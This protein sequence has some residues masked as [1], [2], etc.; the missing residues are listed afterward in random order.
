M[1]EGKNEYTN[2][3][4]GMLAVGISIYFIGKFFL[5]M[6]V[7]F[8]SWLG[9]LLAVVVTG[10]V[11]Y[12]FPFGVVSFLVGGLLSVLCA[13][14]TP[15]LLGFTKKYR[16]V[17]YR[18]LIVFLPIICGITY[19]GVGAPTRQLKVIEVIKVDKN[20]AVIKVE[21]KAEVGK[22]E[23]KEV[24]GFFDR[25]RGGVGLSTNKPYRSE[26]N[27]NDLSIDIN[28]STF[29][30]VE[31]AWILWLSILFGS[32]FVFL[33]VAAT[34]QEREDARILREIEAPLKK[35]IEVKTNTES[36]LNSQLW[37]RENSI[38][39]MSEEINKLRARDQFLTKKEKEEAEIDKGV[40]NSG[41]L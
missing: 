13:N 41:V 11:F 23:W 20:G 35:Q 15:Y 3:V 30:R 7:G 31:I 2:Q 33:F 25:F 26:T 5:A 6:I 27:P 4:G 40:L 1:S 36:Q 21:K 10:F 19:F 37:K 29:D 17:D 9:W 12:V 16:S 39:A 34:Q 24:H 32:P 22:L 14:I 38:Q 8:F 18:M 28:F